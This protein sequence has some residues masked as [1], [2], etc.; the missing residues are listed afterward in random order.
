[1]LCLRFLLQVSLP[2]NQPRL[3]EDFRLLVLLGSPLAPV[4]P[5]P[6]PLL[7]A[8]LLSQVLEGV[9]SDVTPDVKSDVTSAVT[10]GVK[11]VVMSGVAVK[12]T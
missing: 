8:S 6:R 1:M 5:V 11:S 12:I 2:P 3:T 9:T 4:Q 10:P 7:V